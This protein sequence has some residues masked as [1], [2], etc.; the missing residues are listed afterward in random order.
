M[1]EPSGPASAAARAK[2]SSAVS[3]TARVQ[4]LSSLA[5]WVAPCA[6]APSPRYARPI[7]S[8][9]CASVESRVARPRSVASESSGDTAPCARISSSGTPSSFTFT[10]SAYET[11]APV[12][13][14]LEPATD[15]SRAATMPP[16]HDSAVASV[17]PFARQSAST[18]S[19]T[20]VSVRLNR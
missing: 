16:V 4:T 3:S 17:K 9:S 13:T 2:A 8:H 7:S 19:S 15:V 14:S 5:R 18:S 6:S 1:L 11:T 20:G 10:T 12:K